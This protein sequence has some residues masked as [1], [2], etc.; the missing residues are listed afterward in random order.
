MG[1]LGAAAVIAVLGEYYA[2]DRWRPVINDPIT[3]HRDDT[4]CV[5]SPFSCS[6][7]LDSYIPIH[8]IRMNVCW[9]RHTCI[10]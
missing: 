4:W 2:D 10:Y 9:Q 5:Y 8:R 7:S 3:V 1:A 6:H